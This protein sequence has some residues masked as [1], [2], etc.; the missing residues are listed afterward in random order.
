[1]GELVVDSRKPTRRLLIVFVSIAMPQLMRPKLH[2]LGVVTGDSTDVPDATA[3]SV[4]EAAASPAVTVA[5]G[6]PLVAAA[7]SVRFFTPV[8]PHSLRR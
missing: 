1:M 6:P 5:V 3:V 8:Y 7:D 4:S 2:V